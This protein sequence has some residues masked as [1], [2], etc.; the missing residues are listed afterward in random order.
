MS[1]AATTTAALGT[2][3]ASNEPPKASAWKNLR[4]LFPY[5][6]RYPGGLALGL[7]ATVLM[8]FVGNIVP[9]ATGII[10]DVLPRSE[11][12]VSNAVVVGAL[13]ASW[14]S[15]I[16]PFYQPSSRHTLGIYCLLLI[17]L[18]AIKGILSFAAR[19][20]LIGVSRDIEF[21]IRNDLLDRLLILEPEFY[22]RNRTGELMS[23]ATNDL[24]AV[25]MVLGPGI[26][27]SATTLV[28]M[29][30]AIILMFKLSP[31]LTLWVLVPVPGVAVVVRH[32]W[33]VIHELYETIQA[34][35]ATLSAKVQENLSGVRVIRAYAQEMAEIRGFDEP[36]RDYVARNVKLIRTWS[37][38]MPS[39]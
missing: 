4:G 14:L 2:K 17:G 11:G 5:L 18:I 32:F 3:A 15:T 6:R 35:L 10:I 39:L 1:A 33:Q 37:M 27:Y 36:N 21:D 9:L 12:A 30:M 16:I 8:G 19:W 29:L 24:N 38:F 7:L 25:R 23:R 22:V 31:A 20:I 26:M 13:K 28:T 34:A